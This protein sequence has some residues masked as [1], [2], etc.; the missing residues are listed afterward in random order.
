MTSTN[1]CI[2][3]GIN[4]AS[5]LW[6]DGSHMTSYPKEW[7]NHF[8]RNASRATDFCWFELILEHPSRRLLFSFGLVWINPCFVAML[9]CQIILEIWIGTVL[10]LPESDHCLSLANWLE[11]TFISKRR[12][13]QKAA[14]ASKREAKMFTGIR[15]NDLYTGEFNYN[16][17]SDVLLAL[18][19]HCGEALKKGD[20][21]PLLIVPEAIL[22]N[23]IFFG[24]FNIADKWVESTTF[25]G[26][27][28]YV[29]M[30]CLS[31]SEISLPVRV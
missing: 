25:F 4:C 21:R 17:P 24:N 12:I 20:C 10:I 29:V 15:A 9:Y 23:T 7:G 19:H 2:P 13:F 3:F 28:Q 6:S 30:R 14:Q 22:F 31:Q 11:P 27:R 1:C 18:S 5:I 8:H 16:F 26:S